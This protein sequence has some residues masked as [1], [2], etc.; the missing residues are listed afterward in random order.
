M[1]SRKAP[2]QGIDYSVVRRYF[3]TAGGDAA[4]TASYMAHE[5]NLP[6]DSVRYRLRKE[7]A[8]IADWLDA[9]PLQARVLDLGCG[10]GAWTK[11]F[12]LR[13][14]PVVGFE[15]SSSMAE[16]ARTLLAPFPRTTVIEGDV[17][18]DLPDGPFDLIFLGGLC[19]YLDDTDVVAMLG[20]LRERLA[21]G[22]SI[23]LRESTV[24]EG[25]L[26]PAGSYQAVYRSRGLYQELFQRAGFPTQDVRRN[27]AYTN[28]EFAVELV[29]ARRRH[30]RLLPTDSELLGALTWYSLRATAPISFWLLPRLLSKLRVQWPRLQNHFFR[31]SAPAP[32]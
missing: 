5:Q 12:A 32:D 21:P 9:V 31:L 3:Q 11:I 1:R 2:D 29:E 18:Q 13:Y 14:G 4:A 20:S 10:A 26:T 25:K 16:A 7:L 19:M 22:A 15:Q 23:I 24:M 8:T 30:L 28:M 17:R 6:Q 27:Y